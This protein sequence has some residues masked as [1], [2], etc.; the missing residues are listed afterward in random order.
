[1][2]QT[3]QKPITAEQA[4]REH[5]GALSRHRAGRVGI[6][7]DGSA[8]PD[9]E[10]M[11]IP[12]LDM[13][14][15]RAFSEVM[16]RAKGRLYAL[17]NKSVCLIFKEPPAAALQATVT[18]LSTQIGKYTP[19]GP[20][21]IRVFK[22][23][24]DY[25][26]F[27]TRVETGLRADEEKPEAPE[28]P[29]PAQA[30]AEP[31]AE[32]TLNAAVGACIAQSA[33][34]ELSADG[35]PMRRFQRLY[36][37]AEDRDRL[38]QPAE[39]EW[40]APQ[41]VQ[42]I[43]ARIDDAYLQESVETLRVLGAECFLD[44]SVPALLSPV[45]LQLNAALKRAGTSKPVLMVKQSE[46]LQ[47]REDFAYIAK[48]VLREDY[49]LALIDDNPR[50]WTPERAGKA[51]RY[52]VRPWGL[53]AGR[54]AA[55]PAHVPNVGACPVQTVLIDADRSAAL[56]FA[57]KAGVTFVSGPHIDAAIPGSSGST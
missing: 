7:I 34:A 19:D 31:Q 35:T 16:A 51:F 37:P 29:N 23:E 56:D 46:I 55:D 57:R 48:F 26:A 49:P 9:P 12:P 21:P 10:A 8:Y 4:L 17:E 50:P 32:K 15:E 28:R 11:D 25:P 5:V 47:Q 43:S 40:I 52:V 54:F 42:Q 3:Q 53:E 2:P 27:R 33:V 39:A 18:A 22:I 38:R 24:E 6:W 36:L 1:M 44:L 41:L 13:L 14:A 20:R 30:A 45:F